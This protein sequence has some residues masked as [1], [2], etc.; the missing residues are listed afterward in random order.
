MHHQR[1]M[2]EGLRV[3]LAGGAGSIILSEGSAESM[4]LSTCAESI[5]L[6]VPGAE[7]AESIILSVL[8]AESMIPSALFGRVITLNSGG[9]K[10]TTIGNID[11]RQLITLDNCASTALLIGLPPKM[12]KFCHIVSGAWMP[13][14]P[15]AAVS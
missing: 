9:Y 14:C 13:P 5:I 3:A 15:I 2:P 7:S 12:A 4:M 6:S 1:A 11:N 10:K 8:P